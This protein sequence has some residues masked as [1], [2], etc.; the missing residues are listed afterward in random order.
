MNT[1]HVRAA[2]RPLFMKIS[3]TTLR[4]RLNT[5]L[6]YLTIQKLL[7][8]ASLLLVLLFDVFHLF[9]DPTFK[10]PVGLMGFEIGRLLV[11]VLLLFLLFTDPPRSLGVRRI[12]G[13]AAFVMFAVAL[14]S[15]FTY[16]IGIID[17]ILYLEVAI[18]VGLE[19]LEPQGHLRT[20][21]HPGIRFHSA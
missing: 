6:P 19:A 21:R 11:A 15:L 7:I 12:L 1:T 13:G 8:V 5:I 9:T 3:F 16:Q 14:Q 4:A 17:C 20:T 10:A 2:V 18:I